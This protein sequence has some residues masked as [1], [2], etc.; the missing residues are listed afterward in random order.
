MAKCELCELR[1]YTQQYARFV[2]PVAFAILDCD[3]CDTPMAVLG[4]HRAAATEAERALMV[5]AL[6]AVARTKFGDDKFVIDGVMRQIPDH[7]H[8]HARPRFWRG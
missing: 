5:D 7:C 8:I 1:E 4:E 3:S 6:S 2:H